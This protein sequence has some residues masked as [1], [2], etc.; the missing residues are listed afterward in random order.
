MQ[1]A[2]IRDRMKAS[3]GLHPAVDEYRSEMRV[4][5]ADSLGTVARRGRPAMS[6]AELAVVG[7][8]LVSIVEVA[9]SSMLQRDATFQT[10][11]A[12]SFPDA[13]AELVHRI[14]GGD[15]TGHRSVSER[16]SRP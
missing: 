6:P 9:A 7:V 1:T 10:I 8:T 3:A 4:E 13:I 12:R 16:S 5:L 14:V 11:G 15:T 2:D